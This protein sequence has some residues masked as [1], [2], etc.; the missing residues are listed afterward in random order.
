[1]KV[2]KFNKKSKSF[3]YL[4]LPNFSIKDTFKTFKNIF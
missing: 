1:M 4:F 3:L 2:G